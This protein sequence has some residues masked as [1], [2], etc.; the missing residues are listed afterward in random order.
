MKKNKTLRNLLKA[1]FASAI[2]TNTGIVSAQ[3]LSKDDS[4]K[5]EIN[6]IKSDVAFLKKFKFSG[7]MQGQFQVAQ[8]MG[9]A[10]YEGGNFGST[11]D[12]RFMLRRARLKLNY[13][14]NNSEFVF[15][16][17]ASDNG[18]YFAGN[19]FTVVDSVGTVSG[20]HYGIPY[21]HT[22]SNA[23]SSGNG[24]LINAFSIKDLYYK[25]TDPWLQTFSITVG[26][27]NRPFGF[28]IGYS[29]SSR[30]TPERGRMSQIIFPG[31]RDMGAM[32]IIQPPKTS[33]YN[34]FKIE[35]GLY[36]GTSSGYPEYD[37]QKDFIGHIV[38]AKSFMDEEVK[39]SGGAS[40]YNGGWRS[41]TLNVYKM[42]TDAGATENSAT[43]SQKAFELNKLTSTNDYVKRIYK[44]VDAQVSVDFPF[45]ITTVRG[46]YIW[47]QHPG[48]AQVQNT[49]DI[50]MHN[51][52]GA[53]LYFIQNILNS[54]NDI[55][56]KYDWYDPNTDVTAA[57]MP[58]SGT[59]YSS[60]NF[61]SIG[62][63]DLK[64]TTLGLGWI[65]HWNENVK[66]TAYYDMVKNETSANLTNTT[67]NGEGLNNDIMDN[68]FTLRIQYKF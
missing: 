7:Y 63:S 52:N 46:E 32:L 65:Y 40:Y 26:N 5:N 59:T 49:S 66:I 24:K 25:F 53:Y 27:M 56:V 41:G 39:I 61:K 51:F 14:G 6:L 1:L 45:G 17:D 55:V 60:S 33:R 15:Q 30:E 31:E 2:L 34:W 16:F 13:V 68:V 3:E 50:Y 43:V 19:T 42:S 35:A 8:K 28:E 37:K 54:K 44:G 4:L 12:K 38:L 62:A 20:S 18:N 22:G 10:S 67:V 47:G 21:T 29:S 11:T 48:T 64:Y 58:A 9:E 57:D 23:L 36:N